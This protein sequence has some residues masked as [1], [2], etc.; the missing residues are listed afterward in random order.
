M[1]SYRNI[2]IAFWTDQ[3]ID[4]SFTPEDKYFYLYLL[5][6]PHTNICGCY[7]ISWKQLSNET[8]YTKETVL[9]LMDRMQNIHDVIRYNEDTMEILLLNWGKYNW[10][11]SETLRKAVEGVAN[12][13]KDQDFKE[14]ILNAIKQK[15]ENRNRKQKQIQKTETDTVSDTDVSIG[16]RY[17][18]DRVSGQKQK[19]KQTKFS[20]FEERNYDYDSLEK[21]LRNNPTG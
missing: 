7:E 17:P 16:Y 13:I 6:N 5:T 1:G 14:Y 21:E 19:Q 18:I 3:K 20:N 8:G 9:K 12:Y 15:T 4:D 10:S 2:S 11:C